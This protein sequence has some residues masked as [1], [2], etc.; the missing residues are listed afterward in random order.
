MDSDIVPLSIGNLQRVYLMIAKHL[1]W[2][3][4][5]TIVDTRSSF[6]YKIE[7]EE[8]LTLFESQ[9]ELIF[10]F[11]GVEWA[12]EKDAIANDTLHNDIDDLVTQQQ[13]F[14]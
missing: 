7:T 12:M 3:S 5:S 10:A 6:P 2:I 13:F 9:V 11:L 1:Q 8:T 14:Q 4:V